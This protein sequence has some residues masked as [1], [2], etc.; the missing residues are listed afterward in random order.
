[1]G[2]GIHHSV[3]EKHDFVGEI[4]HNPARE[5][6]FTTMLGIAVLQTRLLG[7]KTTPLTPPLGI[8]HPSNSVGNS[9]FR[10]SWELDSFQASWGFN[11]P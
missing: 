8:Q 2:T 6:R 10:L 1:M 3:E 5:R 11:N 9:I 7:N 4:I